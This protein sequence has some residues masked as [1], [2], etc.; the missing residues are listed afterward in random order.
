MRR[1]RIAWLLLAVVS[2]SALVAG[3]GGF[4]TAVVDRGVSLVVSDHERALISIWDPGGSSP[5][6]P[7][8]P[9]EDPVTRDDTRVKLLVVENRV[10]DQTLDL[11]VTERPDSPIEVDGS[12]DGL[13]SGETTPVMADVDCNGHHGRVD[14]L[15]TVEATTPDGGFESTI[16]Y[17]ASVV[18]PDPVPNPSTGQSDT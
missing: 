13:A 2:L 14:A 6:P 12:Y 4:D 8:Y 5:E 9:G 1:R 17:D 11:R 3:T 7:Q 18:C 16:R 10:S 15:L